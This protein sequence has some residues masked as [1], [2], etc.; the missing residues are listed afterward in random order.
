MLFEVSGYADFCADFQVVDA[1][2]TLYLLKAQ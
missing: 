2:G 1:T